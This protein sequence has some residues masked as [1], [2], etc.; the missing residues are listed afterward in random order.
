MV[1]K[2]LDSDDSEFLDTYESSDTDFGEQ[3]DDT[4]LL[5]I[6]NKSSVGD[7]AYVSGKNF[8]W[9]DV[10]NYI[11]PQETSSGISG[12][13]DSAKGLANA[14]DIFEQFLIQTFCRKL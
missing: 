2:L 9:E 11:R 4:F 1:H 7:T 12:N 13:Q 3:E 6:G 14:V 10:D 5:D 8:L